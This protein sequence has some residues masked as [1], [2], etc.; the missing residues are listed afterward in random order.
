MP[1]AK[2]RGK[3]KRSSPGGSSS[4]RRDQVVRQ[5]LQ[6]RVLAK[7]ENRRLRR[8][9]SPVCLVRGLGQHGRGGAWGEIYLSLQAVVQT[10]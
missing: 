9:L 1:E 4:R 6:E 7:M 2:R 10:L 5:V 3:D 8:L